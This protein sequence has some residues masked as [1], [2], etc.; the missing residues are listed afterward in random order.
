MV[1]SENLASH[2]LVFVAYR[3]VRSSDLWWKVAETADRRDA[4]RVLLLAMHM[5]EFH[6]VQSDLLGRAE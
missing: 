6:R 1:A 3:L 2:R 5:Q 4:D